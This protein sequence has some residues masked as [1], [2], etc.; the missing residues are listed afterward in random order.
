M[1]NSLIHL[2]ARS[3][4]ILGDVSSQ[5]NLNSLPHAGAG[6]GKGDVQVILQ[7]VFGIAGALALLMITIAGFR[8]VI[9]S[10]SPEGTAKAK[11]AIIYSLAGLL[12]CIFA[13]AIVTFVL[14]NM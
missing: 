1:I 9:S 4:T 7:I 14:G 8:Y 10:G 2:Y 11:S 12:A 5:I 3:I 13:E 6:S